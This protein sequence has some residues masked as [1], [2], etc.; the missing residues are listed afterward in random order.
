MTKRSWV[1]WA[2]VGA[3]ALT[4]VVVG[5]VACQYAWRARHP[6]PLGRTVPEVE[7]TLAAAL[8]S[9][10]PLD[11]A[12]RLL[13]GAGVDFRV[14]SGPAGATLVG[15]ARDVD[16]DLFISHSVQIVLEFDHDRRLV[17]R[18]AGASDTGM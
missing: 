2:V 6:A 7:R 18:A 14:D 16:A 8:P 3:T 1:R 15:M 5:P 9:G 12:A 13:A 4:L 11:S 10:T 17:S